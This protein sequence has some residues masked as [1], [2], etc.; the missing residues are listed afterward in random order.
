MHIRFPL[1]HCSMYRHIFGLVQ[2]FVYYIHSQRVLFHTSH[3]LFERV[4]TDTDA[5]V[6]ADADADADLDLNPDTQT[7]TGTDVE[8]H[9]HPP[10]HPLTHTHKHTY[11]HDVIV[12]I[13]PMT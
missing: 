7:H 9:P 3:Q 2:N 12:C 4:H 13:H 6:D 8:I 10:T 11:L 5:Y 1:T